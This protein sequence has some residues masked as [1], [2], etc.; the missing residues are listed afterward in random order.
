MTEFPSMQDLLTNP[1]IAAAVIVII[2]NALAA[3]FG[4]KPTWMA[5]LVS[6]LYMVVGYVVT[7]RTTPDQLFVALVYAVLI[8]TP[9][10]HVDASVLAQLFNGGIKSGSRSTRSVDNIYDRSFF[11]PWM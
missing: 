3:A 11:Q 1:V 10:A 7:G 8:V 6:V 4:K 2:V 9:L 5:L